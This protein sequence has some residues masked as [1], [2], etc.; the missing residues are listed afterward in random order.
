MGKTTTSSRGRA[1][2]RS[3]IA[4]VSAVAVTGTVLVVAQADRAAAAPERVLQSVAV[5]VGTD[6]RVAA[7]TSRAVRRAGEKTS[8]DVEELD[9]AELATALPVRVQTAWRLGER[10]G[11][12]LADIEGESGRVVVEVTVQ[13]TTVRA[14]EV[15]YDSAGVSRSRY[16]LVGTPLT[17]IASADL[18]ED[19]HG[20]VVTADDVDP[21]QVTNGVLGR[22]ADD[23]AQ[24]Q[25]ATMLAP[26]R[27]GASA[28]LR[29]VQQTDDFQ[30]PRFDLSVQPGL[31]TDTSTRRLFE[32]AFAEESSSTLSMENR[33]I[34]LIGSVTGV[35]AEASGVLNRIQAE[36]G[37]T[38]SEL[39][40]RTIA[41]LQAGS[42]QVSASMAAVAADL[43]S[44]REQMGTGLRSSNDAA[45]ATMRASVDEIRTLL[46]DPRAKAPAPQSVD[47]CAT[48]VPRAG[49]TA[50]VMAQLA[51]VSGQLQAL[52][53]ATGACRTEILG[54]LDDSVDDVRERL[55]GVGAALR[56][57]VLSLETFRDQLAAR[58]DET[59][60]T[61]VRAQ[62][63]SLRTLLD[64]LDH[65][66]L[67]GG[68]TAPIVGD[69]EA[70]RTSLDTA[71]GELAPA[72][73]TTL[74]DRVGAVEQSLRTV[75][76]TLEDAV[77]PQ[78]G[79]T[80]EDQA[81]EI[82]AEACPTG[83]PATAAGD[84][85]STLAVGV[86]CD[87]ALPASYP[88]D[89]IAGRFTAVD[90]T[91]ADLE[92]LADTLGQVETSA[93]TAA[94]AVRA[95]RDTVEDLLGPADD[96]SAPLYNRR[97]RAFVCDVRALDE[98]KSALV[99]DG[100]AFT[101]YP[102]PP[103][104]VED[105]VPLEVLEQAADRLVAQQGDLSDQ[106][107]R[108]LFAEATRILHDS[109]TAAES[110][111]DDVDGARGDA[112]RR[113]GTLMSGLTSALDDAG[114]EVLAEGSGVVVE[115]RRGLDDAVER[116]QR[117]LTR[118]AA[119]AA[120]DI[121]ADVTASNRNLEA[122]ERLLLADLRRVLV[123]L[124][125]RRNNG[126]G[127]LGSL[128]TGATSTR[129]SNQQIRGANQTAAQFAMVRSQDLD[130]MLLAQAQTALALEMQ[131]SFPAFGIDVPAG[132]TQVTVFSFRLGES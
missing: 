107:I 1:A 58:F 124:G 83:Q 9:A 130:T 70:I 34:E 62:V 15:R 8:E 41:D 105:P 82:R 119:E 2:W 21:D 7:I 46:G 13:N 89:S 94:S 111:A 95:A 47:G 132:S 18:G 76:G 86:A 24:V 27:L 99:A 96:G 126:T 104:G 88:A 23:S 36:L 113:I 123:D 109:V 56:R 85:I 91:L 121:S 102:L 38:A 127:L 12:D 64:A 59:L 30:P 72:G 87:D 19:S 33:T 78:G 11:T 16:A 92:A 3:T 53:A 6:G 20:T 17:V 37:G 110:G 40:A 55:D 51:A 75:I 97:V 65:H 93:T 44:L 90:A 22:G 61:G 116:A 50:S 122:S 115:Q 26:P 48:K 32:A 60:V 66:L 5:E 118:G 108:D 125:E 69:L 114:A 68:G 120:R 49:R 98:P 54:G 52:S 77:G 57:Q 79:A 42:T 39:G 100:C 74:A 131:A 129:V 117:D 28:T 103:G 29:L 10:S 63:A 112:G 101:G 4:S 73:G 80:A 25:W 67:V 84:A 128:V 43:D 106:K 71:L 35:L 45:L 14:Q 31:V 81:L